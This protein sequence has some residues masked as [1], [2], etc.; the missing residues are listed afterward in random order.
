MFAAATGQ[1]PLFP[2]LLLQDA[3]TSSEEGQGCGPDGEIRTLNLPVSRRVF[4]PEPISKAG[5]G[6]EAGFPIELRPKWSST[7]ESNLLTP[8]VLVGLTG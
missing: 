6:L 2:H 1:A 3:R 8:G 4:I 5:T 7:E